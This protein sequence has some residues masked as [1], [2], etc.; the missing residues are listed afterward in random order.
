MGGDVALTVGGIDS[1]AW[2]RAVATV[3][4]LVSGRGIDGD[5]SAVATV[6]AW[7]RRGDRDPR[8]PCPTVFRTLV[9]LAY[10]SW[11]RGKRMTRPTLGRSPRRWSGAPNSS[12]STW[13]PSSRRPPTSNP[14]S[15]STGPRFGASCSS[16]ASSGPRPMGGS[17]V[18]I[19]PVAGS[20]P[21]TPERHDR[22]MFS[23]PVQAPAPPPRRRGGLPSDVSVASY[24]RW[25]FV[26]S[27]N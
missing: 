26:G 4:E 1:E 3:D 9:R 23:S 5:A 18:A 2:V 7:K 20:E 14:M 13:P 12:A 6:E 22:Q 24:A 21:R 15:G 19:S 17:E 10:R 8:R 11:G 25:G 27:S 16:S